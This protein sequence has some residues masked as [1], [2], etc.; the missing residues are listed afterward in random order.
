MLQAA[1]SYE[2][3]CA[4]NGKPQ[5]HAEAKELLYILFRV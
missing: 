5:S 3:H 4:A 2:K 1:K